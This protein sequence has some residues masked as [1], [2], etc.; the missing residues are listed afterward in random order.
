MIKKE[1]KLWISILVIMDILLW[2]GFFGIYLEIWAVDFSDNLLFGQLNLLG[3][4]VMILN[5]TGIHSLLYYEYPDGSPVLPISSKAVRIIFCEFL[6]VIPIFE[7]RLASQA[8]AP[9]WVWLLPAMLFSVCF[10]LLL[11]AGLYKLSKR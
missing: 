1:D 4:F 7:R 5:M 3:L 10:V 11:L 2:L 8:D 9:L 6:A